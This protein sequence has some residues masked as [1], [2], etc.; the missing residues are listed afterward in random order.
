MNKSFYMVQHNHE[1]WESVDG[2]EYLALD[3]A[4]DMMEYYRS[5]YSVQ[6]R[7][8]LVKQTFEVLDD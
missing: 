4:K 8:V 2:H 5:K 1:G 3:A 6:H 7:I